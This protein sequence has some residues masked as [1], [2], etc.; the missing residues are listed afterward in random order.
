MSSFL[1]NSNKNLS[2]DI[3]EK[4]EKPVLS[5]FDRKLLEASLEKEDLIKA[6][7]EWEVI[8]TE[9][10]TIK[11]ICICDH[12]ILNVIYYINK[13]N[14]NIIC[15]GS[16]CTKKFNLEKKE[17]SNKT[18]EK[19]FKLKKPYNEYKQFSN[20]QEYLD[21]AKD[22]LNNL[23]SKE[24][25]SSKFNNLINLLEDINN[26]NKLND[27][28]FFNVHIESIKSKIIKLTPNYIETQ[29]RTDI[30]SFFEVKTKLTKLS[31]DYSIQKPDIT[32]L[33]NIIEKIVNHHVENYC[34]YNTPPYQKK[35]DELIIKY[36]YITK[37]KGK[38][39]F[40]DFFVSMNDKLKAKIQS[41]RD[42]N[43]ARDKAKY[44]A[45]QKRDA[46]LREKYPKKYY[47]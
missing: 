4:R 8:R 46:Y 27:L 18:L 19:I 35:F 16:I 6:K 39:V 41:I 30:N 26:I 3:E 2:E 15:C 29:F 13:Y 9:K 38:G 40:L 11:K 22:E 14:G 47:F 23:I 33:K 17:I 44:E 5:N 28:N 24:I 20:I 43:F 42:A 34:G 10:S 31:N 21:Y 45:K 7:G 32:V 25:E 37:K 12:K 36:E 1:N